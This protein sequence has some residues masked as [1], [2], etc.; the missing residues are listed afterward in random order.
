MGMSTPADCSP[1]EAHLND[2]ATRTILEDSGGF[3]IVKI[4]DFETLSESERLTVLKKAQ[5]LRKKRPFS[6][7][8]LSSR[9][10]DLTP[11][12]DSEEEL[13]EGRVLESRARKELEDDGCP[14][15]YPPDLD[16][17]LR[18]PPEK[19]Q[20]IIQYWK[21]RDDVVLCCRKLDWEIFR[22]LQ[23]M[24]RYRSRTFSNF[25]DEVRERRQR[26]GL[27]HHLKRLEQF[28][29]ERDKLK[30]DLDDAQN[31]AGDGNTT[32]PEFGPTPAEALKQ[33]L[34]FTER[35]LK[36]HRVLLHWIEQRR[37]AMDPEHPT[38]VKEDREDQDAAQKAVR[39]T[40][41]HG[42][43]TKQTEG[44]SVLGK[45]R[46]T[47]AKSKGRNTRNMQIQK[48]KTPGLEPPIQNLDVI[49]QSSNSQPSKHPETKPR[50]TE[51]GPSTPDDATAS[52]IRTYIHHMKWTDI[53]AANK[54]GSWERGV[55]YDTPH[56]AVINIHGVGVGDEE[57]AYSSSSAD[58]FILSLFQII[59]TFTLRGLIELFRLVGR[60]NDLHREINGFPPLMAMNQS[61]SGA[62]MLLSMREISN[63]TEIKSPSLTTRGQWREIKGGRHILLARTSTICG[64]PIPKHFK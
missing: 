51:K 24:V 45:V 1:T 61:E 38:S 23:A 34:E 40:S 58:T 11:P 14:P 7:E 20:A 37:L 18:N 17:P 13:E 6:A 10:R 30:Q 59:Y 9:L 41:T 27:N 55:R 64:F 22:K 44:P 52:A 57:S 25:V 4:P 26:H 29:K 35:N 21:S 48:P 28:E 54:T 46:V 60:E 2:L 42:R 49:L 62:I 31:L 43:R 12:L 63:S 19:Y 39:M 33:R 36:L 15:C 32:L 53:K 5:E 47:K 8:D 3:I 50:R 16:F 56:A